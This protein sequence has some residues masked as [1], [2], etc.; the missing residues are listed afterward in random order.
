MQEAFTSMLG[1]NSK[2]QIRHDKKGKN[3]NFV[4]SH[5]GIMDGIKL[6]SL[7]LVKLAVHLVDPVVGQGEEKKPPEQNAHVE[8]R[9]PGQRSLKQF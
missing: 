6:L 7:N 4:E 3:T 2:S 9:A 5:P 1:H 8:D